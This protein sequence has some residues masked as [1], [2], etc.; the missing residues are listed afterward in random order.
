VTKPY[1]FVSI[2]LNFIVDNVLGWKLKAENYLRKSG[3]NYLILR[4]GALGGEYKA[5]P[6]GFTL[7]QGDTLNGKNKISR[8]TVAKIMIDALEC[9]D[10]PN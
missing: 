2:I 9:P 10:I 6:A 5:L 4:P 7:G 3:L 8:A 1:N